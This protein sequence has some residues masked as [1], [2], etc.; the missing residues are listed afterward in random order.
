MGKHEITDGLF[1]KLKFRALKP[2]YP[3]AV[4]DIGSFTKPECNSRACVDF[5]CVIPGRLY[6]VE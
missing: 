1:A 6:S 2:T 5:F 4:L 3:E